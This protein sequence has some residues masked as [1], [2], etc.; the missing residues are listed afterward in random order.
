MNAAIIH[1]DKIQPLVDLF[2]GS[3]GRHLLEPMLKR[4]R[5]GD[6][7]FF[8]RN[9]DYYL[10]CWSTSIDTIE[11]GLPYTETCTR[12][13]D[14]SKQWSVEAEDDPDATVTLLWNP[15]VARSYRSMTRRQTH[16][17]AL[18][19]AIDLYIVKART[20]QLPDTLPADSPP[21]LFS[22]K[23]FAY[24]KTPDGFILRCR[25]KEDPNRDD[26]ADE[27]EFKVK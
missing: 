7:T 18:K 15:L 1:K 16:V 21:D 11:S 12:L 9:R 23:P 2:E 4:I 26:D 8:K 27:Y 13:G 22:G 17:N 3:L 14:L 25:V 24:S 10:N 6:D 19:T 5:K 20:G